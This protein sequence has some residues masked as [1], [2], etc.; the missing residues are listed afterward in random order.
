MIELRVTNWRCIDDLELELSK[1]NVFIG[2]NSTGKSS[3]AYAI[4]FTS[5]S[6]SYD[7]QTLITQ[8]YGYDFSKIARVV[9]GIPQFPIIIKLEDSELSINYVNGRLEIKR[10]SK[11][12]WVDEYLIPS[13][14][15]GY[16][17]ILMLLPKLAS[18]IIKRSETALPPSPASIQLTFTKFIYDLLTSA[19]QI[20]PFS[21][22]AIDYVRAT[23][24]I[25]VE[26]IE[27]S[28]RDVGS[29]II[30]ITPLISLMELMFQDPFTKLELPPD[31]V[32]DGLLD[33]AIFD[34]MTKKIPNNSLVVIEEPE[35]HKNPL[36]IMEFTEYIVSRVLDKNLTLIT[37]TQS[38]IPLLTLGRFVRIGNLRADDVKI[39]YFTR[40]PWTKVKEIKVY[41]DGVIESLPDFE[42]VVAKLF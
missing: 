12:P 33:F 17:Q 16:I 3:L 5:K 10:P 22:Y 7:P 24:G 26:S 14:R 40:T 4:Y 31:L 9:E 34:S 1:I 13:K 32:P 35:I 8:L 6:R 28:L 15:I 39:Y 21:L 38:D 37:T 11:S 29:Y 2:P 42:E 18:E 20:P 30:K 27:G 41:D 23:T 19:L 36:K 25:K